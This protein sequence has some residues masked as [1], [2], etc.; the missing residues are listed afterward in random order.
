MFAFFVSFNY[1]EA[2]M[3]AILSRIAPAGLKGT[4]MGMYAS[5][6][7]FGAFIG[8]VLG[9]VIKSSLPEQAVFL[10]MSIIIAVWFVLSLAMQ[11]LKKSKSYSFTTHFV[12]EQQANLIAEQLIEMPGVYEATLVHSESVAYLKVDDKTVDLAKIKALLH[13]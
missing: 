1:L 12:D 3:P 4:A 7:F 6:Q 11:P 10:V 8:G 2:T 13:A 9:G 5:C